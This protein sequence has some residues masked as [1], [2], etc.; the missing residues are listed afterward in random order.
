MKEMFWLT[1][2]PCAHLFLCLYNSHHRRKKMTLAC[3]LLSR[4]A[5]SV[6][7]GELWPSLEI[8]S[9]VVLKVRPCVGKQDSSVAWDHLQGLEYLICLICKP[10]PIHRQQLLYSGGATLIPFSNQLSANDTTG[11]V[12]Q[13]VLLSWLQISSLLLLLNLVICC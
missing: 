9:M 5:V 10:S 12:T 8:H 2:R 6:V 13:A 4:G 3:L 11:P 1:E 7:E